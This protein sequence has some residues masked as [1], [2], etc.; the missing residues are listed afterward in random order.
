[1]ANCHFDQIARPVPAAV[2]TDLKG[3]II[4]NNVP[5]LENLSNYAVKS[6]QWVMSGARVMVTRFWACSTASIVIVPHMP[7]INDSC[8]EYPAS[9]GIER[10][11][12]LWM[13]YIEKVRQVTKEDLFEK[14][15]LVR[16]FVGVVDNVKSTASAKGGYTIQIQ[17]RDRIKYLMDSEVYFSSVEITR[18][19]NSGLKEESPGIPRTQLIYDICR[20]A[21]GAPPQ[22]GL[23]EVSVTEP[24]TSSTLEGGATDTLTG[25]TATSTLPG[26]TGNGTAEAAPTS[27]LPGATASGDATLPSVEGDVIQ[28]AVINKEAYGNKKNIIL[29]TALSQDIDSASEINP[30]LYYSK[31]GLLTSRTTT[32][33]EVK[34]DVYL[35]ATTTRIAIGGKVDKDGEGLTFLLNGQLPLDIIKSIAFQEVY[36]TEFFQDNRDGNYYYS[37]R[38]NDS[39][40]LYDPDRFYRTYFFKVPDKSEANFNKYIIDKTQLAS[41]T[42][43][44]VS[45]ELDPKDYPLGPPAGYEEVT[46]SNQKVVYRKKERLDPK[47]YPNGAP[48]GYELKSVIVTTGSRT[49]TK[50][51]Y[52]LI[53]ESTSS[54]IPVPPS[55]T[56]ANQ[57]ANNSTGNVVGNTTSTTTAP[58]AAPTTTVTAQPLG[59]TATK[60][61]EVLNA[62]VDNNQ[63]L[64]AYREEF[65]SIGMKTN[66][67]ISIASPMSSGTPHKDFIL[68]LAT[69]P[70][71]L[72]NV[73]YVPKFHRIND[74]TIKSAEEAAVVAL[75]AARIWAK[76]TNVAMVVLV[77]DPT[78]VPGEVIQVIGSPLLGGSGESDQKGGLKRMAKD[79]ET[80]MEWES[81]SKEMIQD[82]SRFSSTGGKRAA[83]DIKV[84][85][86]ENTGTT[87]S[88]DSTGYI[89]TSEG[90]NFVGKFYDGSKVNIKTATSK[91]ST[92]WS[93]VP[94]ASNVFGEPTKRSETFGGD[95]NL[96]GDVETLMTTGKSIHYG[97]D[98]NADSPAE[99]DP[100]GFEELPRTIWRIEAVHFK[101]NLSSPGFTTEL[102]LVSAF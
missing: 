13:G 75:S 38:T 8:P 96:Q 102:A 20:R 15:H 4:I 87:A 7:S 61:T 17:A 39:T 40:G 69:N 84:E 81:N 19:F 21:F 22:E 41:N 98:A 64:I 72:R 89:Y 35:R 3:E 24:T 56:D 50:E 68:H 23:G 2:I 91:E 70:Y 79:R 58:S 78:L 95:T 26:A 42:V 82:Y 101:Y 77:G 32:T 90:N 28:E 1:M 60:T 71:A 12:C 57:V 53:T 92:W 52:V 76:E 99:D 30:F 67:F 5:S 18:I 65:S 48:A 80:Y 97:V 36:P 59:G 55:R 14:G 54:S 62:Y 44:G 47:D 9:L 25:G 46:L 49:E 86:A 88:G 34:S 29:D 10:E 63:D 43:A 100:R 6:T 31:D 11:F 66:F 27:T 85:D 51:M 45:I 74:P 83:E 16:T 37:P 73:D 93:W 94:F 33:D